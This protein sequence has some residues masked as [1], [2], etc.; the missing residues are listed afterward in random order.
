MSAL[1]AM[2]IGHLGNHSLMW[3]S[4]QIST[5]AARAP[6]DNFVTVAIIL[7]AITLLLIGVIAS[8]D[9]LL[10]KVPIATATAPLT[11]SAAA[12]LFMLAYYEE[13]AT[14]INALKSSGFWAI[15]IQSFHDAG[16]DIFFYSSMLLALVLGL[17]TFIHQNNILGKVGGVIIALFGPLSYLLMTT[18]WPT[19][20]GLEGSNVG[21]K[22]R[23][24]I[25]V[26]WLAVIV[27]LSLLSINRAKIKGEGGIKF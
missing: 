19:F 22:Q 16:L 8:R 14:S 13:T 12:G 1:L 11:G 2:I 26:L 25:F 24:G 9:R 6:Y 3:T 5:Y 20:L 10:S 17:M 15:R 27:F 4:N 23:A 7:Y 21:L 18:R